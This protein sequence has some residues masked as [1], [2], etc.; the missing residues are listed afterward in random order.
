M[1]LKMT[2][3]RL[4]IMLTK[5]IVNFIFLNKKCYTYFPSAFSESFFTVFDT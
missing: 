3:L 5:R 4:K 2:Y 1:T